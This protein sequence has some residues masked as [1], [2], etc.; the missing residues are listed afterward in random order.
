M[1][2]LGDIGLAIGGDGESL[3]VDANACSM[4]LKFE[5]RNRCT[6]FFEHFLSPILCLI[7]LLN[8]TL[9]TTGCAGSTSHGCKYSIAGD[10]DSLIS[11]IALIV[12]LSGSKRK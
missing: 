3:S 8:L 12:R 6:N 9:R 10:P 1:L 7:R 2:S 11:F 4:L 5:V